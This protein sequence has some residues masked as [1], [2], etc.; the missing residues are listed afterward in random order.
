[1]LKNTTREQDAVIDRANLDIEDTVNGLI[2][3]IE[4]LDDQLAESI[5]KAEELQITV[6]SLEHRIQ[7]LEA[8]Q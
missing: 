1:M 3:I 5:A 2:K 6:G 8:K 7:E 4:D